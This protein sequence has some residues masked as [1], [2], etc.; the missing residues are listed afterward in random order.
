MT[1]LTPELIISW[2]LFTVIVLAVTFAIG[3]VIK[4]YGISD[5]NTYEYIAVGFV[6]LIGLI[7]FFGW[8]FVAFQWKRNWFA[9]LVLGIP[10]CFL[11]PAVRRKT[12]S[13]RSKCRFDRTMILVLAVTAFLILITMA[14]YRSD[15]DDS[16]YVSNV[17]LFADSDRLN[18]Y[19]SSFGI[20]ELGTVPMYDFQIWEAFMAVL[21]RVFRVE[22]VT[23]MHTVCL[24]VLLILSASAYLLL[25]R[26]VTK[27][28]SGKAALFYVLITAFHL[29]GGY[30]VY[31]EG[32]FLLSRLWQGKAVYLN[33]V[34]PVMTALIL[35]NVEKRRHFLWLELLICMSAGIALNPTSMYVM[36]FQLL[37]ML[38][39]ISCIQRK[40][41][42]LLHSIP[43]VLEVCVI[44][45]FDLSSNQ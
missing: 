28:D 12:L 16:F 14:V 43:A 42:Y 44:Y 45:G 11:I 25:G 10:L 21:C 1:G 34:L 35:Q 36:G 40:A 4:S 20:E 23:M 17:A 5:L 29:F 27:G 15:A 30:A 33:I 41:G 39:V 2:I 22:A 8:Y 9:V 24:P 37:F 13:R 18:P 32:S 26:V 19:D 7:E 3:S 38:I 6:G 31:S